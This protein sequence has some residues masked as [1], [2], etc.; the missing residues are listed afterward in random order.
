MST[1]IVGII[2]VSLVYVGWRLV[3]RRQVS[4]TPPGSS[5]SGPESED[6]REFHVNRDPGDETILD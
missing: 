3:T 6:N 4:T 1:F 2:C 5:G